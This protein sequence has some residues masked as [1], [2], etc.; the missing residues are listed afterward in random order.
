M[1]SAFKE[2]LEDF[3]LEARERADTVEEMLLSLAEASAEEREQKVARAKR[4]LHTLKGNSGMMGFGEL[5]TL[6]HEIE[7]AV[8]ALDLE[9]PEIDELL[10][11]LD[12]FR[13]LLRQQV[14]SQLEGGEDSDEDRTRAGDEPSEADGVSAGESAEQETGSDD[15]GAE[16][17]ADSPGEDPQEQEQEQEEVSREL[18]SGGVRVLFSEL[19]GL[20]ELLA[21]VLLYR[22]RLGDSLGQVR[23]LLPGENREQS[24]AWDES[25]AVRQSLEQVLDF[26]QER[27]LRLR[28]VP[29][30]TLFR[31]LSRI[32]HD[33]SRR[34]QKK[35][36][37]VTD[38]GDTPLDK[39][40]LELA[41]EA[42]GHLVRN[43]VNHGAERPAERK[44]AGK[45][46]TAVLR[47]SAAVKGQEVHIEVEDDGGGI[48]YESLEALA[49][50]RG[51]PHRTRADLDAL[52]FEAGVS[53][54]SS[55]SLSAGRGVGL[56]AVAS[57]V[58]RHGGRIDLSSMPGE[59][60][61]F[62]LRL[63]LSVSITRALLLRVDGEVYA[64]PLGAV[65]ESL[66]LEIDALER[67]GGREIFRWRGQLVPVLDLGQWFRT[68]IDPR[69]QGFVVI[70]EALG[71]HRAVVVDELVGIRD[72]VVKGLDPL[73]GSPPGL[74]GSTILGDGRA[75]LIL[76]PSALTEQI[77]TDSAAVG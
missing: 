35:V 39:A 16:A 20:V 15:E 9:S 7:D 4:Q 46:E 42:L 68:A 38:G 5:Q 65:I 10:Q 60:T 53:T 75:V 55:T 34:E 28:M 64:L 6:A 52:I 58:R 62:L 56:A 31:H 8:E 61:R 23:Q 44:A 33:E 26:L 3:V 54:R 12:R 50:A 19:D 21:E 22:N 49:R 32:V 67:V 18:A 11:Q 17:R 30:A 77:S 36:R 59:G 70:V 69:S 29:L 24:D 41:S 51:L 71:R 47:L 2:L 74:S 73:L 37:F 27:I 48:H 43:A 1:D 72:I 45:D 63:P 66:R 13:L 25:E 40:L 14:A 57:A 76:D